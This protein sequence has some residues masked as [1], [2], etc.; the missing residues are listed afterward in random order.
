MYRI[1]FEYDVAPERCARF[2]EVYGPDGEWA[3]FFR[4]G[5]GYV[6][7]TLERL[8]PGSYRV[9]DHWDTRADYERFL[10]R[11]ADRYAALSRAGELLYVRERRLPPT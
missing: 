2:E 3:R 7:T 10:E 6:E 1:P 11:N 5:A 8:A 9:T 4:T